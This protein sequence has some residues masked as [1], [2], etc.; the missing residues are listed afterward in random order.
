MIVPNGSY[1]LIAD[2]RKRLLARNDGEADVVRLTLV[3]A[4]EDSNPHTSD[5]VM[6]RAGHVGAGVGGASMGTADAH[7]IEE[8]RF[9]AET[10]ALVGRK[11][12]AGEFEQLIV[13]APPR[14]LGVLRK[15][16]GKSLDGRIASE[17]D[18]DLTGQPID[19]IADA[20]ARH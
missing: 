15:H 19:R 17:I 5:Q 4:A 11:A 13:V 7:D 6:D 10:A 20:L 14:T 2:G 3:D 12:E 16:Y 1:V 9:A 18:R 8:E